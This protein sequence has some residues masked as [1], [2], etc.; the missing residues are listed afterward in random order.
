MYHPNGP[1]PFSGLYEV[2]SWHVPGL[3]AQ[4]K[5]LYQ[6]DLALHTSA[7]RSEQTTTCMMAWEKG[8]SRC[9]MFDTVSAGVKALQEGGLGSHVKREG[10]RVTGKMEWLRSRNKRVNRQRV[11]VC[12]RGEYGS[13][14]QTR[15]GA[16]NEEASTGLKGWKRTTERWASAT[17]LAP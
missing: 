11:T 7:I 8:D 6:P 12:S 3:P 13:Q 2:Y 16:W 4:D 17:W 14:G 5:L 9:H 15:Q 10:Q 1:H